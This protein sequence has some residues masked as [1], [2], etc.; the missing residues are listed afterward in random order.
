MSQ[1][2]TIAEVPTIEEALPHRPPMVLVDEIVRADGGDVE[3]VTTI[4]PDSPFVEDGR[5]PAVVGLEYMAQAAGALV[6]VWALLA[7]G[8]LTG[9][10][11]LGTRELSLMV[12][13]F[14]VGDR[15]Q[16]LCS[17]QWGNEEVGQFDCK[18]VRDGE[19]LV[20]GSLNVMR[21]RPEG[22]A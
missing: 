8:V 20:T 11:L 10:L 6:G 18:V 3:C 19:V 2:P 7:G 4:R 21:T 13:H 5:V 17:H 1:F 22:A 16:I 9:G 15:L 12:D 14:E